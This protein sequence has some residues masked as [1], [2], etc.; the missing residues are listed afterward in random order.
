MTRL[1]YGMLRRVFL[2]LGLVL[3]LAAPASP[4]PMAFAVGGMVP[5]AVLWIVNVAHLPAA[6]AY[7]LLWQWLQ[8]F[9]R[10]LISVTDGESM[11]RSIYGPW[12]ADAYWY[13]LA[14]IVT[15]AVAFRIV[16]QSARPPSEADRSYHLQWRPVDM[17]AVYLG[18]VGLHAFSPTLIN[19]LPPLYQQIDAA[20][21]FK[22]V[23]LFLLSVYVLGSGKG[24]KF[25]LAAI[26][27]EIV[28]GFSGIFSDFRG[29]F[30]IVAI[31]TLA[32]RIRW[33]ASTTVFG[34]IW[35]V[36]LL[37]LSLFWTSVKADYRELATGGTNT[38][39]VNISLNE[40]LGY[41]GV[42]AITP[43]NID[44]RMASYALMMRL[45]YVDIFGS[46][47]NVG[48]TAPDFAPM[49]QWE[50]AFAHVFK[51]RFLF[52]GKPELSD[53]EVYVRL[54]HDEA[55]EVVR[56]GTSISVGYLAENYADLG[57]PGMLVGVFGLG[58]LAAMI[59]RY[60]MATRMPWALRE[61]TVMAFLYTIG[62]TGVEGSLPKLLGATVMFFLV[63]WL[64]VKFAYPMGI[65][66]LDTRAI[67]ARQYQA[68]P[69]LHRPPARRPQPIL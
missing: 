24:Q 5:F 10:Q 53:T 64:L 61:G 49:R 6:V 29:V 67:Q 65:R 52:P 39:A 3:C 28:M 45:A 54:T 37:A 47:V 13:M 48:M 43:D 32:A 57:F 27:L 25:L 41:I 20:A 68:R 17:F 59:A 15:L 33:S 8:T 63:Y 62:G 60:F 56:G 2:G 23:G 12:V 19:I 69:V 46:V 42:R 21:R 7:Y 30:V 44:W 1:D 40:R 38:Q 11:S 14:S 50:D 9:A 22:V 36:V 26:G 34:S 58:I 16:F 4:D 18:G 66:W 51:P 35:L 31:A 55:T